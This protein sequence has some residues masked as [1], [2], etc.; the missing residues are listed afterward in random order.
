MQQNDTVTKIHGQGCFEII[1]RWLYDVSL[2]S[3]KMESLSGETDSIHEMYKLMSFAHVIHHEPE[4]PDTRVI[5]EFFINDKPVHMINILPFFAPIH[6]LEIKK[7]EMYTHERM[8]T[9]QYRNQTDSDLFMLL[10][11]LSVNNLG[12]HYG[13]SINKTAIKMNWKITGIVG[14]GHRKCLVRGQH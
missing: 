5:M 3:Y 7:D 1:D 6:P 4:L 14:I 11:Q 8:Y 9:L 2:E 13:N 10:C 12:F